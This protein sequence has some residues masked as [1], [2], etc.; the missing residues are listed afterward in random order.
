MGKGVTEGMAP[1]AKVHPTNR[2]TTWGW[3][4]QDVPCVM[5]TVYVRVLF[6]AH[7]GIFLQQS[8]LLIQLATHCSILQKIN[9]LSLGL[10]YFC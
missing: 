9:D 6:W 4:I 10:E 2:L 1:L 8:I 5:H 3:G 7:N